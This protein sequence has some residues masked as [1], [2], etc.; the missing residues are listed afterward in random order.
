MS[1]P[2]STAAPAQKEGAQLSKSQADLLYS[3]FAKLTYL[4]TRVGMPPVILRFL[5]LDVYGIWTACFILIGY[6]SFADC[7][8]STVYVCKTAEYLR[9]NAVEK[10]QRLLATG[11]GC[12]SAVA[13]MVWTGIWL[14]APALADWL[15]I[16]G[17]HAGIFRRAVLWVSFIFLADMSLNAFSYVLHGMQEFRS[18]QRTWLRA[19]LLEIFAVFVLLFSGLGIDAL[20]AA[21]AIRYCYSITANAYSVRQRLPGFSFSLRHF[22][23]ALLP[24]I[25]QFGFK[26]QLS[27]VFSMVFHSLDRVFAGSFLGIG[28]VALF[29]L[30]G[31]FPLSSLS[32]ASSV[33][34][35][36]LAN[37]AVASHEADRQELLSTLLLSSLRKIA[38]LA[39]VPLVFISAFSPLLTTAWLGNKIIYQEIPA[40]IMMVSL[41]AYL[42]ILTGPGSAIFRAEAKVDREYVYH[43][44]RTAAYGVAAGYLTQ[45]AVRDILQLGAITM[46]ATACAAVAYHVYIFR[47]YPL[48]AWSLFRAVLLPPLLFAAVALVNVFIFRQSGFVPDTRAGAVVCLLAHGLIFL[49]QAAW[50]SYC[51]LASAEKAAVASWIRSKWQ[52]MAVRRG[53]SGDA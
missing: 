36:T 25:F 44:L 46:M 2:V 34:Q 38:V 17:S 32:L 18:E 23:P 49:L 53:M 48:S 42:H 40:L 12:M 3:V 33:T 10:V 1:A 31:K 37:A 52:R 9:Q 39:S 5:D 47:H 13:L 24:E 26:V 20:I 22:S 30:A 28:A 8:F 14:S 16:S 45:F 19:N 7:G 51:L 50:I 11:L 4:V 41:G 27:T 43:F 21:Y 29:D 6:M 35:M 15:H